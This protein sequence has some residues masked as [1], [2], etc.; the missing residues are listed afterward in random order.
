[1]G[2][3]SVNITPTPRVLIKSIVPIAPQ[4]PDRHLLISDIAGL[5]RLKAPYHANELQIGNGHNVMI[6][7]TTI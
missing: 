4:I 3:H 7:P 5:E 2:F 6:T 1:M